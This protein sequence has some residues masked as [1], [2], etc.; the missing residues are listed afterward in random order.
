MLSK[1]LASLLIAIGL[2]TGWTSAK[3]Q[4]AGK[5]QSIISS[6]IEAFRIDDANTAFGFASN[7]LQKYFQTPER[8]MDMVKRGY[9]PV[10]RPQQFS[11][12]KLTNEAGGKPTQIVQ[13]VDELGNTWTALYVFERHSD[14]T[15]RIA[16]VS[17]ER[18]EGSNV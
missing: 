17:L 12:G 18:V 3:A 7:T 4:D 9:K 5:L 13:I 10:Y 6:Q 15:W 2:L 1:T 11:F 8:F 16:S 14:G